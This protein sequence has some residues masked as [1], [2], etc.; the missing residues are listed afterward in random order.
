VL[1]LVSRFGIAVA[2]T[3]SA[4]A[5]WGLTAVK[6]AM[7]A[8]TV[9][10]TPWVTG[11]AAQRSDAHAWEQMSGSPPALSNASAASA[12]QLWAR[13]YNGSASN[14]DVAQSVAVSPDGNTVFVTGYSLPL[15]AVRITSRSLTTPLPAPNG[16][17]VATTG[18]PE[19]KI[20]RMR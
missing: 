1:S 19:A 17:S 11:T 7:A 5:A 10:T 8:G 3:L 2:L 4:G 16:G 15:G 9:L 6:P 18:R 12:T 13:R 20:S 14:D